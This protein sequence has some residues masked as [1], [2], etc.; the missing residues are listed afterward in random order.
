MLITST[1]STLKPT[2]NY[3]VIL[4]ISPTVSYHFQVI[5][6]YVEWA[7]PCTDLMMQTYK[8]LTN[9]YDEWEKRLE[10]IEVKSF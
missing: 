9:T 5:D 1:N 3:P 4:H 2:P 7:G 10:F 8:M 6:V